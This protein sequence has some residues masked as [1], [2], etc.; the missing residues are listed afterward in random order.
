MSCCKRKEGEDVVRENLAYTP[1]KMAE[2]TARGLPV[3]NVN[4]STAFFEGS[5][6]ATYHVGSERLRGVD[7]AELW[8]QHTQLRNKAREAARSKRK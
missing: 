1:A 8:E 5:K 3:N 4:A 2:L 7:V 6:D